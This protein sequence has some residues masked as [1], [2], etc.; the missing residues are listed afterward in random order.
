MSL[1]AILATVMAAMGLS[2]L[3]AAASLI[4]MAAYMHETITSVT[5]AVESVHTAEE[6]EVDLLVHNRLTEPLARA[7]LEGQ[8]RGWLLEIRTYVDS[9]E[10]DRLFQQVGRTMN[11]Y[12]VDHHR[13]TAT[14]LEFEKL[15]RET[16]PELEAAFLA[17]EELVH[18]NVRQTRDTAVRVDYW[19]HMAMYLGAGIG[20]VLVLTVSSVLVW[21]RFFAFRSVLDL[22]AAMRRFA[23]G[24]KGARVAVSGPRELR[25]IAVRFNEMAVALERQYDNRLAFLGGVVHDL[26][27]PL[28]ALKLST[29]VLGAERSAQA[30]QRSEKALGVVT[31][32]VERLERMLEDLLD[33]ARVEAGHL[34][35][36]LSRRDLRDISRDVVDTFRESSPNHE[37]RL[38]LPDQPLL[39]SCD[40]L[41][42]EQVLTNLVSNAIKYSPRGG[43]VE[44]ALEQPGSEAILNV[45]DQGVGIPPDDQARIFEPFRRSGGSR[46]LVPGAGLGLFVARRIVEAHGGR[47][48]VES[49]PG[50][51][52]TFRVHLPLSAASK[53]A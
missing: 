48:E 30:P 9:P 51:G 19:D 11:D 12:L 33:A 28:S 34:E 23:E 52:S 7:Q 20:L 43:K 22:E 13:A 35:L 5:T 3:A 8:L 27:N 29:A 16:A 41:R 39:V 36:R 24:D 2:A 21:L 50:T 38:A 49:Q 37:L 26:R 14:G 46:D 15:A 47:I 31:R 53:A 10:E 4:I 18:L 1:R 25:D 45:V 42:I 32:Q 17:L 40:P 44:V 6:M